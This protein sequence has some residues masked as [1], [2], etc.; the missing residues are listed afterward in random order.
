V[1]WHFGFSSPL[2]L[3]VCTGVWAGV[4]LLFA[5]DCDPTNL[6]AVQ[7]TETVIRIDR[8]ARNNFM[9]AMMPEHFPFVI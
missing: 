2:V 8:M 4:E 7:A 6:D 5:G 9:A 1:S 3:L